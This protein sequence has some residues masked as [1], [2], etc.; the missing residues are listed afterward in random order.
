MTN[1]EFISKLSKQTNSTLENTQK[2]ISSIIDEMGEVFEEGETI[3]ISGLGTFEVKKRMERIMINPGTQQR[4]LIP[5][6]LVLNFR[7]VPAVKE[8]LKKK[9]GKKNG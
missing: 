4:M 5:P 6:K 9:G 3:Q 8:K 1:K 7:P 2:L